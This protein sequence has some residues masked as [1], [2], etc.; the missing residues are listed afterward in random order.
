MNNFNFW[1]K[2]LY[3]TSIFFAF[4]GIAVALFNNSILFDLWNHYLKIWL[5]IEGELPANLLKF[6][7]FILAP[8]GGTIAG[9]YVL[10][11]F[12]AKYPFRNRE[13]WAW[14]AATFSLLTWFVVDSSLCFYHGAYFNI[15]LINLFTLV[16]Q[17]L[18]LVF[19]RKYFEV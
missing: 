1:Q 4:V 10:M 13:K 12:I 16:V 11:A 7:T 18:P 17:G 8:L 2:W 5:G 19:T 9:S 3:Y 14:Q 6:K 15:V